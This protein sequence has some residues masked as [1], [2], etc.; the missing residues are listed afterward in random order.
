M[1]IYIIKRSIRLPLLDTDSKMTEYTYL[2][3]ISYL[4]YLEIKHGLFRKCTVVL[5][6]NVAWSS[7]T[8]II[9]CHSYTLFVCT[10]RGSERL[11][12]SIE[13]QSVTRDRILILCGI[14]CCDVRIK[15]RIY[16][17]MCHN[18]EQKATLCWRIG[19]GRLYIII[20]RSKS[21]IDQSPS[22]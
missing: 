15:N 9:S 1:I 19:V 8:Y 14:S 6:V 21:H 17:I 16:F 22:I 7:R 4:S 3:R 5:H 18:I 12:S 13:I 11:D 2:F 10:P 20:Y